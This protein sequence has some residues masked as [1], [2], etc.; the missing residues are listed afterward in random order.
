MPQ[1][2]PLK[3]N[4]KDKLAQSVKVTSNKLTEEDYEKAKKA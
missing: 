1:K 4:K 2:P 3:D